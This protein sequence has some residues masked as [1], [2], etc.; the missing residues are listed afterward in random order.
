MKNAATLKTGPTIL[1]VD[2]SGAVHAGEKIWVSRAQFDG[3]M[4]RFDFLGRAAD[5]PGG[6]PD[7]TEAISA[8]RNWISIHQGAACGLDFPFALQKEA[9]VESDYATWLQNFV[10][11]YPNSQ[12]MKESGFGARRATD[13]AAKT[14]FSPLNLRLYR[15]TYH[16]IGE[17]LAPLR[18]SGACVLPFDAPISQKIWLLEICPASLLK[19]EKLYL[20]YKGKSDLQRRNREIIAREMA[21]RTPFEWNLEMEKRAIDDTEGDALDAILAAICTF[22]ALQ[23]PGSLTAR[24]EL[25]SKEGRVY[26]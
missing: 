22:N 7:R 8:L 24:S 26:F 3:K 6:S 21:A 10:S 25:E 14:P 13:I 12:K 5:L 20:S 23:K 15:Q 19:A 11:R 2:F 4:L 9:L 17:V 18:A 1:G 16:G